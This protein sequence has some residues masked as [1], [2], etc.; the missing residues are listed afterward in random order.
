VLLADLADTAAGPEALYDEREAI[1]LA[2]VTALQLLPPRQRAVLILRDV[3]DF[4]ARDVAGMIETTEQAV[5]SALK[6]A[7]AT[8]RRELPPSARDAPPVAGSVEQQLLTKFV[9][10]F[11]ASDVEAIVELLTDD[12]WLRMPPVPLEYQGRELAAR[13]FTTIAFRSGRRYRLIP[14]GAN[15]QPAFGVYLR[16]PL[17]HVAHAFGL[18]VITLAGDRVAAITRFDNTLLARFGLPRTLTG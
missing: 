4:S 1:S 12:V 7:R 3:L 14:T 18:F 13:F 11:E 10:A 5:T 8:L 2:F 6:R 15:R 16:D 9:H 17:N